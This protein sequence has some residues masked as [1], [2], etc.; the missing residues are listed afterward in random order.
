M[1]KSP[2]NM[3]HMV[4]FSLLVIGGANWLLIGV[5]G[6]GI[7]DLFGGNDAMISRIIYILVGLSAVYAAVSHKGDCNMCGAGSK[8]VNSRDRSD[9]DV[10]PSTL[11]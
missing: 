8:K 5:I 7:G 10:T 4:T 11:A 1:S 3:L 2:Q 9:P 6:W